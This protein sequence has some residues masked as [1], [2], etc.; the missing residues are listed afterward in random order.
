MFGRRPTSIISLVCF[1][2]ALGF[3]SATHPDMGSFLSQTQN[4]ISNLSPHSYQGQERGYVMGGSMSVRIPQENIRPFS[5]TPPSIRAG[6]GGIDIVTGGF[7]YLN[8]QYLVKKL[9]SILQTAPAFAFQLA[10][11]VLCPDCKN[12]LNSLEQVADIINGLNI[13]SCQASKALVGFAGDQL[14]L[15]SAQGQSTGTSDAFFSALEQN[16]TGFKQGYQN[17]IQS[18][19]GQLDCALSPNPQA[20]LETQGHISFLVPLVKQA[21]NYT[22]SFAWMEDMFRARYGD[23]YQIVNGDQNVGPSYRHCHGFPVLQL[24]K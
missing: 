7:S 13:N 11:G 18:Y 10:L 12:I 15:I 1:V 14:G 3:P 17:W 4:Q 24:H 21:F 6:C 5:F 23:V 19:S 9:Q 2:A 22:Q 8:F 20:C 16:L